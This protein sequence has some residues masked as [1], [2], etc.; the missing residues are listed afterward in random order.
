MSAGNGF[1]DSNVVLYLLSSDATK[2]NRAEK[3]IASQPVISVQVLN[4]AAN[5]MR[6]KLAM[7]WAETD[8]V[9][10][11]VRANCRVEPLTVETHETGLRLAREFKISLYD[12][13]IAS[14]ALLAGCT[15]L[16]SEDMHD[17]LVIDK[18]LKVRN[19][20]A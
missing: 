15:T 11:A 2:A 10:Q 9:L 6:K 13:M 18:R 8:E 17:G 4:E 12:A 7:S 19:P 14:S 16:H 1:L 20:F 3:L 5:V